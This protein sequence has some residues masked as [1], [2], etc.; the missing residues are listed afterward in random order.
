M[1]AASRDPGDP[2]DLRAGGASRDRPGRKVPKEFRGLQDLWGRRGKRASQALKAKKASRD[3]PGYKVLRAP[4]VRQDPWAL[5]GKW[6]IRVPK[7]RLGPVAPKVTAALEVRLGLKGTRG[8]LVL[9]DHKDCRGLH[10]RYRRKAK[11]GKRK[12]LRTKRR[13]NPRPERPVSQR[14]SLRP[15]FSPGGPGSHISV[16]TCA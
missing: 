3:R 13:R 5:R 12:E 6:A 10:L 8:R 1:N 15:D 2:E 7:V 14:R 11:H 16:A 4:P 9:E